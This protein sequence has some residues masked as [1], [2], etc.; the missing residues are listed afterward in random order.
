M[1]GGGGGVCETGSGVS[2]NGSSA[3]FNAVMVLQVPSNVRTKFI[4]DL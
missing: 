2:S 3:V 4:S 1:F